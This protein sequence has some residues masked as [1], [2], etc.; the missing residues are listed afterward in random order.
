MLEKAL[1]AVLCISLLALANCLN[2]ADASEKR[3]AE[4]P[5]FDR[6]DAQA[7]PANIV[8]VAA[9]K[10]WSCDNLAL[11]GEVECLES[12]DGTP[13]TAVE[14]H[15]DSLLASYSFN[16]CRDGKCL[17]ERDADGVC[18]RSGGFYGMAI[19]D[20]QGG[21]MVV[22]TLDSV[23]NATCQF[24]VNREALLTPFAYTFSQY[25]SALWQGAK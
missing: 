9:G 14:V 6:S 24:T 23:D 1:S 21:G 15:P 20:A 5:A 17:A 7:W 8:V 19:F 11:D 12:W 10:N 4:D 18:R 13:F 3:S 2:G 25:A 16:L 22:A